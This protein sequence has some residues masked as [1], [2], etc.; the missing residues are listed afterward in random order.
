MK[1]SLKLS[2]LFLSAL[3]FL[4]HLSWAGPVAAIT[5]TASP[6]RIDG[7]LS[8][9]TA[10]PAMV[11]D[12]KENV[13]I[14]QNDWTGPDYASAKIYLTYDK[15]NL[16]VGADITSKTPQYNSMNA[17][18]IY[19]GDAL[20]CYLGTDLSDPQRKSYAPTDVQF[21]ISPGKNGEDAEIF[22]P[23]DKGDVP[24]AK[25]ATKL[26]KKGYTLEASIPL[27]YFY[28][29]NVGP[30]KTIGFDVSLDDVGAMAKTRTIQLAWSGSSTSWQDP[31]G[32]GSLQFKGSTVFVN[33]A[34]K[35]AMPGA[36]T[37]ELDPMAG[38][39]GASTLGTLLWGFNGDLGGF[40]GK[41][42]QEAQTLTEGTGSLRIDTDGSQGWNQNLAVSSSIPL[43]DKWEN[44][45]AISMDVYFPPG[46]LAKAG[47][48]ELYL[49]TQSPAN[50]WNEIKMGMKEGWN[51]VK[52]DVD[53]S[54]FKGGVTKAYLVFNSGGPITGSVVIDN[55]RG[56]MKGAPSLLTGKVLNKKTHK[57]V[58]GADVAIAKKLV[59]TDKNGSFKINL[60]EDEYT[61]EVF[62]PG[63]KSYKE[64]IQVSSGRSNR[65]AVSLEPDVA[66]VKTAMVD[67]FFD[68]KIRTINPHYIYG[69]N[70]AAWYDPK[71]LSDPVALQK[72][73]DIA[74][75]IR[76]PGGAY[77]NVWRWKTGE[78]LR[79][80][81][82]SV[83]WTPDCKWSDMVNFIKKL[84]N[85][86][87]L[88]IAN[89]M[90]MDVQN[91][92]DWIADAKAQGLPVKYVE[93]GNEPDYEADM[94][95]NGQTQYWTVIDNYCQHFNEFAK[96]I[97]AKY[98]DI[99]IM[100]PAVAQVQ[101]HERKEGSPWLAPESAPWWVERFLEKSGPY[102]DVVS[103]HSYP[104]W[105]NDSDSNLLS[106]T[107]IWSEYVPQIRES[108]K[109]NIPDRYNQ[110]EIAVSEWNS[111]DE[112]A[113][114]ARLVN[115]I[116]CA[117]YLA[118]MMVW[119]VNQS[120][121]WD[122]FTQKPGL[123]GGHGTMDPN[124]D[125]DHPFR[126][127]AHYWALDMMEHHFGTTLYQAVSNADDLSAY[128]STEG[129]KKYL[130]VINKSPKYAYKT[131]LN[132]GSSL[133][134][135]FKPD[136]YELSSKEYQWSEN[137]Y[138]AVIDLGPAHLKV[139]RPVKSRFEYTFPPYSITCVELQPVQ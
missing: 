20:E 138:R 22:S 69:N 64:T 136:F 23:T 79:K 24:D 31:S 96:A 56:V 67:A 63:F 70:I 88:M 49:I 54:Q 92:L 61:A 97:K 130:M 103:V 27:K 104:Y 107:S 44:F 86:E 5:D 131:A 32:W 95:Y 94:A 47:Y 10:P 126:E 132:L 21:V 93:L 124:N 80:D 134:G 43:A 89:M 106:K 14:G 108:I 75:F 100:G 71:W 68:K 82:V 40:E 8:D 57:A 16:Y 127:R 35:Q 66:V 114:T 90:T 38:K 39:K 25:V 4:P 102:V 9:W 36:Q 128:A 118:Q 83:Q 51:H 59:K 133:K 120:T 139:S 41:V 50:N 99:K 52:Q 122:L 11:L 37:M 6:I 112:N 72:A 105:S 109:K 19:N 101:N 26:T 125:P 18:N 12:K 17:S 48:G 117:D 84:P 98:P 113:T 85:G 78:V 73:G 123:G 137:L 45:K 46:S 74:S 65:W 30:G 129:G 121:I 33:T 7:D 13:V 81:G 119:G 53:S 91:T 42:T 3:L 1:K 15:K 76:V 135:K 111:G 55:I 2:W 58:A 60:P 87:P 110:V 34:P 77:G 116:F 28:K 29:I 115:G 62:S